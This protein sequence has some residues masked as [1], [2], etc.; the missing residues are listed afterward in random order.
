ML[1]VL[2]LAACAHAVDGLGE[3]LLYLVPGSVPEI[4]D[5]RSLGEHH[6]IRG[7]D[8]AIV[9]LPDGRV[10]V[11]YQDVTSLTLWLA[12]RDTSGLWSTQQLE[13]DGLS[14]T[15]TEGY[16]VSHAPSGSSSIVSAWYF[17][18]NA[19]DDGVS[20]FWQ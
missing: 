18:P 8:S 5:G 7:D 3:D 15:A 4:I 12:E 19:E 2:V 13:G 16:F 9:V 6:N 20:L 17:D 1:P 14:A 11:A 10:R